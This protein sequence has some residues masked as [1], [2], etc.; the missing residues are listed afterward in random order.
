MAVVP[1]EAS[2]GLLWCSIWMDL[3]RLGVYEAKALTPGSQRGPPGSARTWRG[4]GGA[5]SQSPALPGGVAPMLGVRG[6]ASSSVKVGGFP[7][8]S[9]EPM[10][11][12]VL[13]LASQDST[14][15]PL[16]LGKRCCRKC[17]KCTFS[18]RCRGEVGRAPRFGSKGVWSNG[19][20]ALP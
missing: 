9:S 20:E 8:E 1:G 6:W 3:P 18:C 2:G 4:Q 19:G 10:G 11:C 15:A 16:P 14:G 7:A 5:R 12:G 13:G 17:W